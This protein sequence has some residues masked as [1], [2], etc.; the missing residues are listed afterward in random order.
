MKAITSGEGGRLG[1]ESGLGRGAVENKGEPD[2]V[3]G[4]RK[5]LKPR[6]ASRKNG[7]RQLQEIGGW[8][9]SSEC[10]RDKGETPRTQRE[11]S[12]MKCQTVGRGN[13]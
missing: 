3:F 10:T 8:G 12:L 1:K 6:G 5:E 2:L 4:E 7:N 9:D 11:V 13:L